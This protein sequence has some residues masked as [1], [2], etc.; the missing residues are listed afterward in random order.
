MRVFI[1]SFG[2]SANTADSE[3]MAGC[4]AEA[5]FDL[6]LS[7]SEADLIIFNT[8]AV[9]GQTENRVI[10]ALKQLPKDKK[11]VVAGC[12]PKISFE[13]LTREVRFDGVVGP[14]IGEGIVDV[15]RRVLSG[16]KVVDLEALDVKP[17]LNLPRIRS[18]PVV[19][20]LPIN[21]GCL[22]SCAYCCVVFARGRL[23]SYS[24]ADIVERVKSDLV[25]GF[26]EFWVTSQDTA[27]FGR[28]Q[29]SNLAELLNEL[30][31][32]VGDFRVRVGMMTPNM[33]VDMQ[34]E[35]IE[36]YKSIKIF[37]FLHLPIQSGDD[38]TLRSMR[39]F[40]TADKFKEIVQAFRAEFPD[41]TLA[42]DIIVGFPGETPQAF[43][44]TL[45]LL[46]EIKPDIVNVSKFFARPKTAAAQIQE[47]L[48]PLGEIKRRSTTA[49]LLSKEISLE[50]NKRWVGWVGEVLID[51]KGKVEGS[52]VGRNFAYKPVAVKSKE[53][54]LGKTLNV[55]VAKAYSTYLAG[56]IC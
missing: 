29:S 37:K 24:V 2:C 12:L 33:V 31:K 17:E 8:C 15:S 35:L 34:N 6:A 39:R 28:D 18:N 40:Y 30:G 42:T 47:G 50:R 27:C 25:C 26:R 52:W 32:V 23:R 53:N 41:L 9:K 51:E 22:G 44:K 19:S 21:Y 13:R 5:G 38:Q 48:I 43:Q 55:K 3:V 36:A 11:I 10:D 4:L 14:S 54:V 45:K 46:S 56:A 20:V 1:R 7:T 16:E 49:A